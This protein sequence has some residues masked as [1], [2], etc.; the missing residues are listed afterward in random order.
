MA[1]FSLN[2]KRLIKDFIKIII[3]ESAG[4]ED[5][6]TYLNVKKFL[7]TPPSGYTFTAKP[8]TQ[9]AFNKLSSY[10][11]I[12]ADLNDLIEGMKKKQ[13]GERYKYKIR[14]GLAY[15]IFY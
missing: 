8:M 5:T 14:M 11:T 1:K 15:R 12:T 10:W 2:E 9:I 13:R 4:I 3:S 6:I 7:K